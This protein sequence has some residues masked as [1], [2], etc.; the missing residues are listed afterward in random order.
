MIS[1]AL[2]ARTSW[3]PKYPPHTNSVFWLPGQD[4]PQSATIRDRSGSGNDGAITEAIWTQTSKGLWYLKYDGIDDVVVVTANSTFEDIFDG[5]GT[6]IAWINPG[7]D[8]ENGV[9]IV[10]ETGVVADTKGWMINCGGE[11]GGF[12][13]LRLFVRFDGGANGT[14][15]TSTAI[16]PIN[17]WSHIAFTY[18][19]DNVANTA[20]FYL[21]GV[22][23]GADEVS[24]TGTRISDTGVA[25]RLGNTSAGDRTFDGGQALHQLVSSILTATQVAGIYNAQ[26]HL[27]GV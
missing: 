13:T 22:A 14:W 23:S 19:A 26:R 10:L 9:A 8:G 11:A 16:V 7:S 4:D 6:V 17:I 12:I 20:I 18:N 24:P 1:P 3:M 5:G 27:F 2:R 21:N 15:T 25:L